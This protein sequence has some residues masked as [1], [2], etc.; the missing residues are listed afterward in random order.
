[1]MEPIPA[2][3]DKEKQSF[4]GALSYRQK[5]DGPSRVII[6]IETTQAERPAVKV[7]PFPYQTV[8]YRVHFARI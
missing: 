4:I 2:N 1:M 5:S 7:E 8:P 3:T 6:V